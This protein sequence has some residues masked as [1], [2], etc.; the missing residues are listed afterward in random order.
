LQKASSLEERAEQK[1][2]TERKETRKRV[3]AAHN[4]VGIWMNLP[5]DPHEEL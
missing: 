5:E 2:R 1:V 3:E 4:L